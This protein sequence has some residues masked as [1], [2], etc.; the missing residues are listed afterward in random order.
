MNGIGY[1]M[2]RLRRSSMACC[3]AVALVV[4]AWGS[5]AFCGRDP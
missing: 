3:A 1:F 5:V 4:L 2:G